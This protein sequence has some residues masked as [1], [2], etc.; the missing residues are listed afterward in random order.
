MIF[1]LREIVLFTAIISIAL[2]AYSQED[3]SLPSDQQINDFSLAGY[4]EK[5]KKTWDI[6]GKSADVFTDTV[7]L[8]D[9][10]SN[11]YGQD[12]DVKLTA[13]QGDFNKA[14]GKVHLQEN[15]VITTTGGAKLTTDSLDWDRKNQIVT[16]KDKVNIQKDNMVTVA[17]G[18]KAEPGLK[19]VTLVKDVQVDINPLTPEQ[20]KAGV[21]GAK[22]K[23]VITCNG[24]VDIN[25]EKNIAVFNNN[26]KVERTDS[27][28]YS[29]RMDVYFAGNKS[30][31]AQVPVAEKEKG[32]PELMGS[33]IEKIVAKGNVRIVRGAN[34]SY[35]EEAVYTA[36]DKKIILNGRPKLVIYSPEELKDAFAGD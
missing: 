8:Q 2:P 30:Q 19:N 11:F 16:S 31:E 4:G 5:G 6:Y 18:A 1:K 28:I 34:V 10:V 27:T 32:P 20:E 15:V 35:S 26:V 3:A 24:P 9:V 25:Y 21:S 12:E 23:I 33:S 29:D 13:D 22:E 36:S 17:Q 14:D 7:K